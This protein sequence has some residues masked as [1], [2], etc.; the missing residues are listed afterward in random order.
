MINNIHGSGADKS[1]RVMRNKR[2]GF[3]AAWFIYLYNPTHCKILLFSKG[4]KKKRN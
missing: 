1:T 3:Q 4:E 2:V